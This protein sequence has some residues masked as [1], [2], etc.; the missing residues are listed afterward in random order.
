[1]KIGM[2]A[3]CG[4]GAIVST[5]GA[6]FVGW[7]ANVRT[8]TGGFLVNVF[9]VTSASSDTL[10]NVYGG[11]AGT[12]GAGFITTAS[13][14][15]FRQGSGTGAAALQ[16]VFAPV[17]SQSWT[18]L[19]SFLTVG[20]GLDTATGAWTANSATLGDVPWNVTY[21]DTTAGV[22]QVVINSFNN[23]SNTTGFTNPNVN[24]IPATAGWYLM[25][26]ASPARSLASLTNRVASSSEAAASGTFGMMVA[27]LFVT[28]VSPATVI[29][30]R[31]GA[32]ME[33]ADGSVSSGV[34]QMTVPAPGAVA[35]LGAAALITRRRRG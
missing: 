17:G 32:T 6:D 4:V 12:A 13:T 3:L 1:M 22:G 33:R 15:G 26:S 10:L 23:L 2:I 27:Q 25:G 14:G 24:S 31:M 9:A 11:T 20:G 29:N 19:D 18:T 35:L 16:A 28:D 34:F 21:T 30:W 7:T 8:V 5:A